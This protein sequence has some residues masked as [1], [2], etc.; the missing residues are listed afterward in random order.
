MEKEIARKK[1]IRLEQ[2]MTV[3]KRKNNALVEA[4]QALLIVLADR[5]ELLT[6]KDNYITTLTREIKRM[7]KIIEEL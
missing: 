4:N 2:R 3:L 6:E 7:N 5:T 1:R